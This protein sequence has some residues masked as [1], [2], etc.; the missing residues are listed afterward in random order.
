LIDLNHIHAELGEIV[1][2]EKSGRS[3]DPEITVF[4]SVG[5]AAQDL[6]TAGKIFSKAKEARIG[7]Y[8]SL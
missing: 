7:T 6:V 8:V 5:N 3:N 1:T 4:K 2:G